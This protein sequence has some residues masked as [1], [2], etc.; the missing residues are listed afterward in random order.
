MIE[1]NNGSNSI[2][3][4][5]CKKQKPKLNDSQVIKL[6]TFKYDLLDKN[7]FK[8]HIEQ[9]GMIRLSDNIYDYQY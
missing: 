5:H 4:N 2:S 1:S 9:D 7:S 6:K 3:V 8:S